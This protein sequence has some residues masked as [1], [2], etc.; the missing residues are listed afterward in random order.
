MSANPQWDVR[1]ALQVAKLFHL[2]CGLRAACV[3][4]FLTL[5][6]G[7]LGLTAPWVGILMGTKHLVEAFW[8]PFCASLVKSYQKRRALLM[9]SL[10]GSAGCSLLMVLLPRVDKEPEFRYCDAS[11]NVTATV[12]PLGAAL[13]GKST[14]ARESASNHPALL[15]SLPAKRGTMEASG[16]REEPGHQSV[17]ESFSRLPGYFV[18]SAEEA[19]STPQ[20]THPSTSGVKEAPLHGTFKVVSTATPLFAGDTIPTSAASLTATKEYARAL[21]LSMG[22]L[23]WTF[24]LSLGFLVL[25]ELLTSPLDQVADDSLYEYLDFVDAT[26]GYRDLWIWRLLGMSV[27]VCSIAVLVGQLNCFLGTN[28]PSGV[29]HFYGYV[30]VSALALLVSIAFPIPVFRQWE[31]SNKT[32][33]A[34]TLIGGNPHLILLVFTVI[35][36][37]AT[38]ST[39]Q[40]FLFWH[41]QNYGS[42]EL[43]MGFSVALG[44][45]GE[46]LLHPLKTTLLRKLS[47]V[48][49]VGLGLGCLAG[50]LL[51]YSLIWSW[52]SVLPAQI[53]SAISSGAL[54]WALGALIKD[55]STPRTERPLS[56]MFQSYFYVGGSSLGSF[57]GGFVVMHYGLAV[58]Y[59]TC[60]VSLLLWLALFL[61]IQL[62]LPQE[63]KISYSKL[64]A[65]QANDTSDAEQEMEQDWLVKA[66]KEDHSNWI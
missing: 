32:V 49:T 10:L 65:V 64:L 21:D 66:M 57:V 48:G 55:M 27:G 17:Q 63:Q 39:V 5:Y 28:A 30:L 26:D 47:R 50:Q 43:V 54:W 2:V 13:T 22:R 18:G 51:Y 4:P 6:L 56:A 16:V 58:L 62:K 1:R 34:L 15:P 44:L 12:P 60:C 38:T 29:M 23:Q 35:L 33:K 8:A 41:M 37:G 42:S 31:P 53:L 20:V 3:T 52:W 59:Q 11:N 25:W 14:L 45:L 40:N 46:V 19:R 24:L 7:Q 61:S 36:I 9:G